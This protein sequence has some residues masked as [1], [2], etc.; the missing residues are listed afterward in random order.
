MSEL[1]QCNRCSLREMQRRAS[2]RGVEVIVEP[3]GTWLSARYSDRAEPSAW[4]LAL[5]DEC[6]C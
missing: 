1:T 5:S 4:F 3:D 2:R 6:E